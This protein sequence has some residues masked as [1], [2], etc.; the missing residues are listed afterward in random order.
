MR[1][2]HPVD[3]PYSIQL[4]ALRYRLRTPAR[5]SDHEEHVE[6]LCL[7]LRT[8]QRPA[9]Y[10][11]VLDI[12]M[13]G[14]GSTTEVPKTAGYNCLTLQ[15]NQGVPRIHD[16]SKLGIFHSFYRE[17]GVHRTAAYQRRSTHHY[18]R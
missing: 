5:E 7:R 10:A 15:S 18:M 2:L 11:E 17:D 8:G 14:S 13:L 12:Q 4:H 16:T 3:L 1:R 6:H 9:E